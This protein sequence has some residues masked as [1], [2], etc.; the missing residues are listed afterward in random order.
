MAVIETGLGGR[1]DST[2]TLTGSTEVGIE[3]AE[4]C[5]KTLTHTALELGGNDAFVVMPDADIELAASEVI[6]GRMYNTG[7]VC[8]A[9]KR[10]IVHEDVAEEFAKKVVEKIGALK[11]GMPSEE[12]TQIGC[13]IS[14]KAA[15][16]VEEQIQLT[17]QQG[18]KIVLGGGRD[19]AFIEPTVIVDVPKTA[20]VAI[21]MEI[22]EATFLMHRPT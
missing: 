21:D 5:A 14:E 8:C 4:V 1:L 7:Q 11:Q 6:W 13:L 16:T 19:G 17:V 22:F 10:F 3:T 18:G 20:D 15:R 9:S 2:N 12:D